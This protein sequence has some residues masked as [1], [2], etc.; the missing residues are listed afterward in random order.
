MQQMQQQV[1]IQ[2]DPLTDNLVFVNSIILVYNL[3]VFYFT[4]KLMNNPEMMQQMFEN[5]LVQVFLYAPVFLK[6]HF[7]PF[8]YI[9]KS[10]FKCQ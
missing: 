5:P 4:T 1:S 3:T 6:G 2:D 10:T 7:V 9:F 8:I